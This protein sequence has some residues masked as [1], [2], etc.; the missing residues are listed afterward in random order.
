MEPGESLQE[1]LKRE[2]EEE[3][4]LLVIP[5]R[6]LA[7]V[8]HHYPHISIR[9]VAVLSRAMGRGLTPVECSDWRWCTKSQFMAIL[10][11]RH[12]NLAPADRRLLRRVLGK[13]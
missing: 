10:K 6:P 8:Y 9:L 11:H 3:L 1:A 12:L 7:E 5:K 2:I 13:W 4:R